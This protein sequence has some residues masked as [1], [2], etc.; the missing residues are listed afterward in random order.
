[1]HPRTC[2]TSDIFRLAEG[3]FAGTVASTTAE[4]SII[5]QSL[6]ELSSILRL[7]SPLST[8]W[9]PDGVRTNMLFTD[10]PQIPY[11]WACV[12]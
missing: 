8:H 4:P 7:Q 10:V 12:V 5:L 1:M 11:V 3:A 9:L 2:L 6:Y